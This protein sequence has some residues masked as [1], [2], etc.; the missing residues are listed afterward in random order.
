M[1]GVVPYT[2][3]N[4]T[5]SPSSIMKTDDDEE[6]ASMM[7]MMMMVDDDDNATKNKNETVANNQILNKTFHIIIICFCPSR[8]KLGDYTKTL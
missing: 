5:K 4:T 6:E 1:E 8:G 2:K 7:M 3:K